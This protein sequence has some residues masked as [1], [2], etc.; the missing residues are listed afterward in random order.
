MLTTWMSGFLN[1][2]EI[3]ANSSADRLPLK[4]LHF[5]IN[6]CYFAHKFVQQEHMVKSRT[7]LTIR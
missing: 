2:C 5:F 7:V 4:M 1:H 3:S 6:L